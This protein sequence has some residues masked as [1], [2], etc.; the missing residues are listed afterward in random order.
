[1]QILVVEDEAPIARGIKRALEQAR[2]EVDIAEDGLDGLEQ[3]LTHE[4]QLIILDVM[5][6]RMDGLQLC[7]ELRAHRRTAPILMLTARSAVQDRIKGL[8]MGA[9]DY[10]PKPIDLGELIARVQALLRRERIHRSR[11]IHVGDLE[12]DSQSRRVLRAGREIQLTY[13]EYLL[14]EAL[15]SQEGRVLSRE[16]IQER[17]WR[18]E[19]SYSNVVDVCVGQLRKKIDADQPVKLIQTVR[20]FGYRISNSQTEDPLP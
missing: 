17:I 9:D 19:E 18:D 2:F 1:M 14:L 7:S 4:Y 6:P 5:L 8:E 12:I 15:A 10:L 16:V 11:I 13:K 20:G 3:A